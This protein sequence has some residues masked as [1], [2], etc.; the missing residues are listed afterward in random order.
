[1]FH[2]PK[3]RATQGSGRRAA[4]SGD[5]LALMSMEDAAA[6]AGLE[7]KYDNLEDE[8]MTIQSGMCVLKNRRLLLVDKRLGPPQRARVIARVLSRMD[9]ENIYLPP[10]ARQIIEDATE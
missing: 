4:P 5:S 9:L 2:K 7:I 1:M 3:K 8:E 6:R 10:M